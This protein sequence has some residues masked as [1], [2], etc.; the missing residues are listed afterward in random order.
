[1][2]KSRQARNT[3]EVKRIL[4]MF[5]T[6]LNEDD[7]QEEVRLS[8]SGLKLSGNSGEWFDVSDIIPAHR[9]SQLETK[10]DAE[11]R[12][13]QFRRR[14]LA[15]AIIDT[16]DSQNSSSPTSDEFNS[17]IEP[18]FSDIYSLN[19]EDDDVL[20]E[21]L[22]THHNVH[23][24]IAVFVLGPSAAGKTYLTRKNLAQVLQKNHLLGHSGKDSP[25]QAFVSID[26]GLIRDVSKMWKYMSALPQYMNVGR[27]WGR[28]WMLFIFIYFSL[29]G[30]YSSFFFFL[31]LLLLML[32]TS[33]FS[34]HIFYTYLSRINQVHLI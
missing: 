7:E 30:L 15:S 23:G 3:K 34:S 19:K 1:M 12:S 25:S 4:D 28:N 6:R 11:F 31:L 24:R 9:I 5:R 32:P 33:L 10:I 14:Y 21:S 8:E 29:L 22:Q 2:S 13:L 26:G 27:T 18:A 20:M 16:V 17:A